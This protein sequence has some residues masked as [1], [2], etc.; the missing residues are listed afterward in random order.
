MDRCFYRSGIRCLK[1]NS[2]PSKSECKICTSYRMQ[3]NAL[4]A[5]K[6]LSDI[7]NK[8]NKVKNGG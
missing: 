4:E 2:I 7:L 3:V 1:F 8:L 5:G 6:S